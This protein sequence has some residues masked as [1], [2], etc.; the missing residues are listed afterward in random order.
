M[1]KRIRRKDFEIKF[2]ENLIQK[3]PNFVHALASLGDA[4]TRGGFYK[5]GLAVDKRLAELKPQDPHVH[6]N[7]AC[8]LSL[9][10]DLQTALE[11]LKEAIVLGYDDFDYLFKDSDLENLRNLPE[12]REFF[13]KL[14][15]R[16][17]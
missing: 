6:Y 9:T 5:E 10:G 11:E 3:R 12:C 2:Y 17:P 14:S 15:R 13:K 16:C 7:L 8:S 1:K 4:Y